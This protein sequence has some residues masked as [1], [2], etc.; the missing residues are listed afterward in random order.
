MPFRT[1]MRDAARASAVLCLL[2]F[3]AYVSAAPTGPP[4]Q[5]GQ[6][7]LSTSG[8]VWFNAPVPERT[9]LI[10]PSG[11]ESCLAPTATGGVNPLNVREYSGQTAPVVQHSRSTHSSISRAPPLA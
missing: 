4:A 10:S 11:S 9:N 1:T 8:N 5:G 2:V 6:S 7:L 3:T